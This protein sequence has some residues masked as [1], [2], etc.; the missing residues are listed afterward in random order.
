MPPDVS[1]SVIAYCKLVLHLS[2]Y[3]H[4]AVNGVLLAKKPTKE[5]RSL[6]FVDVI[7]LFHLALELTP[8]LEVAMT[9]IESYCSQQGL[10]IAGYYHA[11][12]VI[13]DP[14]PTFIAKRIADKICENLSDGCLFMV[15]MQMCPNE[16]KTSSD[17]ANRVGVFMVKGIVN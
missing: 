2:K 14:S 11:G 1:V 7:P 16:Q 3:P 6:H 8:M 12:A 9:Q 10:I 5:N 15:S 13:G 17:T 4:C